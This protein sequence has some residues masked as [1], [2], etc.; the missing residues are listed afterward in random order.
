M[1][2]YLIWHG[3]GRP[4]AALERRVIGGAWFWVLE[5]RGAQRRL[6]RRVQRGLQTM[7]DH[8]VRRWVVDPG[9]PEIWR[10][11]LPEVDEQG[12]R[13]ALLPQFLDYLSGHGLGSDGDTA[14]ILAPWA[15][16]PV[17]EAARML[18][19]RYRY[20]RL[21]ME[22]ASALLEDLW[23]RYGIS[24][25]GGGG[26]AALQICFGESDG[27]APALLLGPGCGRKQRAEYALPETAADGLAPYPVTPQLVAAL[28]ECGVLKT[29][30]IRLK[31]LDFHA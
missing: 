25:G 9:W 11:G 15:D 5:A 3:E 6:G 24:A 10:E 4:R 22:G 28:W 23:R 19:R 17:W 29:G 13:C 20:L 2:G 30:E 21:R 14:E 16:R 27:Q 31:S 12:L 8:G 1:F 7:A 26:P 18:G